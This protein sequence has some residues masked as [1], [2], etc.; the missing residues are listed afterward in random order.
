MLLFFCETL[1][2]CPTLFPTKIVFNQKCVILWKLNELQMAFE[3]WC[4]W[5][6]LMNAD[7]VVCAA[8]HVRPAESTG[9]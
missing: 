5:S 6:P 2:S 3:K 9:Q 1:L 4:L 7:S 8:V